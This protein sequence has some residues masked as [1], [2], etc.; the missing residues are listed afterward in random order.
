MKVLIVE[1]PIIGDISH[2]GIEILLK[3]KVEVFHAKTFEEGL[4]LFEKHPDADV[5]IWCASLG[6][7]E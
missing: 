5:M 1:G 3:N 4:V 2:N 6:R 7:K